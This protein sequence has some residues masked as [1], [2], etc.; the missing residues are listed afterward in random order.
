MVSELGNG[1]QKWDVEV[2]KIRY[3]DKRYFFHTMLIHVNMTISFEIIMCIYDVFS[4]VF[5]D[6]VNAVYVSAKHCTYTQLNFVRG[7]EKR[8][9]LRNRKHSKENK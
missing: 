5:H 6:D 1:W 4:N 2:N 9:D 3:S 8:C 7:E